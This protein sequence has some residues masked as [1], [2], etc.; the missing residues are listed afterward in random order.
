[1]S[2]SFLSE[3]LTGQAIATYAADI[4]DPK[5]HI[6]PALVPSPGAATLA[7]A[8]LFYD[9]QDEDFPAAFKPFTDIPAVSSTLAFKT[10]SE[11]SAELGQ[12]VTDGIKY[13]HL[14]MVILVQY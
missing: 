11:F 2:E 13:A 5:T 12:M 7:S 3:R 6:V 4:S 1:L 10:L 8:I 14:Y 9:S